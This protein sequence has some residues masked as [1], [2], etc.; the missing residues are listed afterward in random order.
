MNLR[1][2]AEKFLVLLSESR[3]TVV[4]TGAGVSTASG[5][6]DF[7]GPQGLYKKL[8]PYV[9]DLD[10]FLS[11][12]AEYYKI[13]ADRIHNL[14]NKEPN[15]THR[16]LAVLEKKGL[17]KGIITQNIDGLHQKAGSEKV[18]ELHGNAQNF[19]CM[20]CGKR[21]IVEEILKMLEVRDI[22]KCACGGL[23]KPDV[24]FFGEALPESALAEAYTL[25][26]NAD[27]FVTMGTSLL[28]YPAAHFP[29]FAKQ[30]GAKLLIIN[31]GETGLDY[32]A[33]EKY[34]CDLEELS[35]RVI[36]LLGG[37]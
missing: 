19:F 37:V 5:I 2:L 21:Y 26:E 10:F 14:F 32:I 36:S 18:I 16:L 29:T 17:T 28:V 4:L 25:S 8:P 11:Q 22:P 1:E 7:R 12:P 23:I 9:F 6:P 15:A 33:D 31:K 3:S 20:S 30:K 27:L 34:E 24:V 13:A 35:E